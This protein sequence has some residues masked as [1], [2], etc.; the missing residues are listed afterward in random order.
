MRWLGGGR[1]GGGRG[2]DVRGR[3]GGCGAVVGGRVGREI[4]F[5]E[6]RRDDSA[7]IFCSFSDS[8]CTIVDSRDTSPSR[9]NI[10]TGPPAGPEQLATAG[11]EH[12]AMPQLATGPPAG[13]EQLATGPPAGPE[14]LAMPQLANGPP[15]GPWHGSLT[16]PDSD[17]KPKCHKRAT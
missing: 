2:A 15:A 4:E 10:A 14:H 11:P 8:I 7:A 6:W 12:L 13:P 9:V 1:E 5:P 3:V 16:A 17:N